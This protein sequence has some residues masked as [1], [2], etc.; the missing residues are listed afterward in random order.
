M[1]VE[2]VKFIAYVLPPG[3]AHRV[4][5]IEAKSVDEIELGERGVT[6]RKGRDAN[7]YPHSRIQQ[8]VMTVPAPEPAPAPVQEKSAKKGK[9][10]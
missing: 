6:V 7:F 5:V 8:V 9:A 10:R 4:D 1:K 3:S 2:R